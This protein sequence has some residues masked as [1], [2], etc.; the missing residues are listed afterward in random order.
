MSVGLNGLLEGTHLLDLYKLP[1]PL[2]IDYISLI[3]FQ[4]EF[5]SQAPLNLSQVLKLFLKLLNLF[6]SL[7]RLLTLESI[8]CF[9]QAVW[10]FDFVLD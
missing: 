8:D 5:F 1:S 3:S 2:L 10:V 7:F 6:I 9:E 4:F